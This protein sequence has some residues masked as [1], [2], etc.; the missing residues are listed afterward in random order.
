[1]QRTSIRG[2]VTDFPLI[3]IIGLYFLGVF[4]RCYV[5]ETN[6]Q[7]DIYNLC[8]CRSDGRSARNQGYCHG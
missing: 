5:Y 6:S 1:M 7:F 4:S 2:K 8:G 3:F